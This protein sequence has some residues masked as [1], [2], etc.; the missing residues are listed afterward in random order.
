MRTNLILKIYFEY[1][2]TGLKIQG[3]CGENFKYKSANDP[4]VT[5][6]F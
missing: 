2:V 6:P 5:L 1:C 4:L 3:F